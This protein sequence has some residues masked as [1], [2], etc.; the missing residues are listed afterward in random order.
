MTEVKPESAGAGEELSDSESR[1]R[2]ALSSGNLAIWELDLE[3][4]RVTPSPELNRL[5]GFPANADPRME[6]YS[7]RYAPGEQARL[8]ALSDAAVA[9]GESRIDAEIKIIHPNGDERWLLLRAEAAPPLHGSGPRAIGV[10]IDVTQSK[11]AEQALRQSEL[12]FRLSQEAAGIATVEVDVDTGTVVGSENL[13]PLWGLSPR[14]STH[15]SVLENIVLPEYREVRS[16]ETTRQTGTAL[17]RAEYQIRRPDTGE[18]RW[19]SR[20]VEFVRDETGRPTKMFGVMQDIT[21]GKVAEQRQALLTHELEHRIKNILATV[22]AIASQT[23]RRGDLDTARETFLQRLKALSEAHNLLTHTRWTDASL[24]GV[25]DAALEPHGFGERITRSGED[26]RL[27]PRM[28]LSLA[29]AVNELTTNSIKYGALSNSRGRVE[30]AW[31][32]APDDG[33]GEPELNW[34]WRERDG[35]EVRPPERRGFGSVLIE[36]VLGAD[37]GGVVRVEYAPAGVEATLRFP[38]AAL[39]N[40]GKVNA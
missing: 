23:L 37:F 33:N 4:R 32:I 18:V 8:Q 10:L 20:H 25:L 12:R 13:W 35:P 29:L 36:R 27:N 2:L 16:T 9:R 17:P 40:G 19:I 11:R 31:A 6:D 7:A 3:K 30:V 15:I 1:L 26:V 39:P 5:F 21:A 22:T 28:A 24:R 38:V 14:G 34:S